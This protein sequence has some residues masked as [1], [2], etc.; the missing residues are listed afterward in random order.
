[1]S[2]LVL[3]VSNPTHAGNP[4]VAH[5]NSL[6]ML[7]ASLVIVGYFFQ[8]VHQALIGTFPSRNGGQRQRYRLSTISEELSILENDHKTWIKMLMRDSSLQETN[9][10]CLQR[11]VHNISGIL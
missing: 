10:V 9:I 3:L 5:S 4:F 7:G 1:M 8:T 11:G 6:A 2:F